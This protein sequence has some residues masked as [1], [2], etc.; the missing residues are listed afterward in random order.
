VA[1][2]DSGEENPQD[3]FVMMMISLQSVLN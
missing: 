2:V 1:K 3:I